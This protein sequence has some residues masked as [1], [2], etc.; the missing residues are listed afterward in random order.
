[1]WA[2]VAGLIVFVIFSIFSKYVG[3]INQFGGG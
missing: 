2:L 3:M 1:V